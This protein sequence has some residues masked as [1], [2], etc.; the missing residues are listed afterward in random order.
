LKLLVPAVEAISGLSSAASGCQIEGVM[1]H[2]C[3][4]LVPPRDFRLAAGA[5]VRGF[6]GKDQVEVRGGKKS[7]HFEINHTRKGPHG[8]P[9]ALEP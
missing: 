8:Y 5:R 1:Q 4:F 3:A 6:F 7:R 9:L 2:N